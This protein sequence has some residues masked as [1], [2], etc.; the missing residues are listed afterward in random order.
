MAY[1]RRACLRYNEIARVILRVCCVRGWLL[2]VQSRQSCPF[3]KPCFWALRKT[4]MRCV[5]NVY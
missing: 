4:L 1:P 3:W 2:S 5:M